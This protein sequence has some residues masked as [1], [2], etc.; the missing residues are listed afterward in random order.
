MLNLN[1]VQTSSGNSEPLQLIPD[2]TVVRAYMVFGS[3][4]D[5]Q[6]PEFS[7][8]SVF[9][10]SQ[11]TSAVWLP[12]ELTIMGGEYDKRKVWTNLFV[13]GDAVGDDGVPKARRIG[14]ETLRK[15]IDSANNLSMND[16]SP[17]AQAK[18]N[19]PSI[20]V[21]DG[22]EV[23]V[24]VGVEKGTNGYPDK[25]KVKTYLT[26]DSNNFVPAGG[27]A[28]KPAVASPMPQSVQNSMNAQSPAPSG[29]TPAWAQQ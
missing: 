28:L 27:A 16:M 18:R 17:E 2:G 3:D 5:T 19:I 21:L 10:K 1:E 4:G 15:M 14:L 13:H 22:V 9:R 23:C 6:M 26:P 29:V 8:A 11:N 25:N 20:D 7:T 24:V 12:L